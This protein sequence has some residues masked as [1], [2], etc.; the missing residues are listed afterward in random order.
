MSLS[1]GIAGGGVIG[2]LVALKASALGWKVALF[3]RGDEAGG[4]SCS[5]A[6]AGM[7]APWCELD[8]AEKIIADLGAISLKEWPE[9]LGD[10]GIE[11]F[12]QREGSLVVAHASDRGEMSRLKRNIHV[13]GGEK[14][15]HEAR[16]EELAALEPSLDKSFQTALY[17]PSEGQIDP[18]GFMASTPKA[19]R[20]QKIE[21][22]FGS[23]V[24][25]IA[26]HEIRTNGETHR[27]D[28]A[29]D[30]R[31]YGAASDMPDLRAVRGE[32]IHLHAPDVRLNRPI[33]LL[34]P[35]WP[36]YVVPRPDNR[37]V[38]GA[39]SIEAEDASPISVRSTL[40]LLSAVFALHSG[41]AEARVIETL[42]G[43]RPAFPDNLPR[44]RHRPGLLRI[45]GL[46]RHGYLL[47]PALTGLAC[48][49]IEN[50][51]PDA[52]FASVFEPDEAAKGLAA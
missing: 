6:A 16:T 46:Y 13:R 38:V 21:A 48:D 51:K 11:T 41:F 42:T 9:M 19:M 45:N 27:F 18:R 10:F 22:R 40:E 8:S 37:Y 26:P 12:F 29:V 24:E 34:H 14:Y 1:L 2:R 35:R 50:G 43:L 25:K 20:A 31:G 52:A 30:C 23:V 44:I 4:A 36:L 33:R 39:T 32:I 17:F 5:S 15:F 28:C 7:L 3:E 49:F 47:A